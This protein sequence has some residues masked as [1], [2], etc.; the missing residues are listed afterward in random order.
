MRK[1]TCVSIAL[2]AAALA[3]LPALKSAPCNTGNRVNQSLRQQ[4]L[5]SGVNVRAPFTNVNVQPQRTRTV[6]ASLVSQPVVAA[7]GGS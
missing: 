2:S 7:V 3:C 4:T 6:P 5:V 1:L